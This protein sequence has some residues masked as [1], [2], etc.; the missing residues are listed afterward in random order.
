MPRWP[1]G[2]KKRTDRDYAAE[3]RYENKK[4]QVKRREDRNRANKA[5]QRKG[6]IHKGDGQEV[7]HLGY[8]RR[9][10]LKGV[11]TRVVSRHANRIRQ[12]K[13]S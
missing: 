2:H 1:S 4:A 7:D 3:T 13:R 10:R 11:P 8:H 6:L 12:P 9:G 5:A